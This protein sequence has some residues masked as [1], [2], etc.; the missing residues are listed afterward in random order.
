MSITV[1]RRDRHEAAP[2]SWVRNDRRPSCA[3]I[4]TATQLPLP[5]FGRT[6]QPHGPR[7]AHPAEEEFA[8][9]LS[10]HHVR[11]VYEPTSFA[12]DWDEAGAPAS[13]F[14]PDFFLPDERLY[15][16]LT[17]MRQPL[18]TQKNR[19]VRLLRQLY[20]SVRIKLLYRRDLERLRAA[21]DEP[22]IAPHRS[23][24]EVVFGAAEIE[25]RIRDLSLRIASEWLGLAAAGDPPPVLL[26]G[27]EGALRFARHIR[28]ELARLGVHAEAGSLRRSRFRFDATAPHLRIARS[29]PLDLAGRRVL[30]LEDAVSTGL[31]A[32]ATVGWLAR[33]GAAESR[34]CSLLDRPQ[35]RLLD[36][37]LAWSGFAAPDLPLAGFGMALHP[38]FRDLPV[39]AAVAD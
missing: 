30:L 23:L 19:K 33:Q 31:S 4:A 35:A 20:P 9:L 29:H 27:H 32:S 1:H 39:I 12:I 16:E 13:Y 2:P 6:A 37:P 22:A 11:W 36:P 7:F 21:Y 38:Q 26:A 15:V 14:R 25:E 18:V 10:W 34:I 24:G 8:S 5:T 17:T 28:R 3:T